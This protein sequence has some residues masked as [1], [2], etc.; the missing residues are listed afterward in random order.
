M[1]TDLTFL[2]NESGHSLLDRFNVLLK[3]DTHLFDCLVGYFFLSGFYKI[4]PSLEKTEKIRILIGLKTDPRTFE[5]IQQGNQEL[6]FKSHAETKEEMPGR[7]LAEVKP[8]RIR[9]LPISAVS[10]KNQKSVEHLVERIL[11]TKQQD[12]E[13]D[14]S[15]LEREIDQLVY[16]LYDLTK[17]EIEIVERACS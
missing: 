10:S 8:Q 12:V 5:L 2:T 17:E 16:E 9:S 14:T 11:S 3:E 1:S 15:A 6:N 4:Y 13:A 7:I